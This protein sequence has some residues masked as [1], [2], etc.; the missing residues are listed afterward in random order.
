MGGWDFAGSLIN[1]GLGMYQG[2]RGEQLQRDTNAQNNELNYRMWQQQQEYD[3]PVNQ[4]SRLKDAGLNPALMYGT[5]S[6]ANQSPN[7]AP[8]RN[9][10]PQ[11]RKYN[12]DP[13]VAVSLQQARLL[14]E[15]TRSL[16]LENDETEKTP[17]ARRGDS[18][19]TRAMRNFWN[20]ARDSGGDFL[21]GLK[22][23]YNEYKGPAFNSGSPGWRE[24]MKAE[25][26]RAWEAKAK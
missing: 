22:S 9:E 6:G 7:F 19:P 20:E 21:K 26:K 13:G 3:K 18:A 14:G 16:K 10:A 1:S 2:L 23:Y 25:L 11:P 12:I 4:V 8:V 17:G 15:Q 24:E 5:G